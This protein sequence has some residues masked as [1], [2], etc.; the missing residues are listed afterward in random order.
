MVLAKVVIDASGNADIA[1]AAG[2]EC[3]FDSAEHFGVQQA[4]L[5]RCEL[6]A[7][8]FNSDWTYANDSDMIDRWTMI[9]VARSR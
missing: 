3:E 9:V 7:S 6:G 8:Y 4:G 1:A 2:A 5:P